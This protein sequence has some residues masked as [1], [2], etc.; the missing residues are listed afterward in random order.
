MEIAD[1]ADF[2]KAQAP[3]VPDIIFLAPC[4]VPLF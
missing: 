1:P 3:A 2:K 4:P